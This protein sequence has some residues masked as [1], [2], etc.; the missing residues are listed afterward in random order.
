MGNKWEDELKVSFDDIFSEPDPDDII[1][2]EEETDEQKKEEESAESIQLLH[3][4]MIVLDEFNEKYPKKK[5]IYKEKPTKSYFE[6]YINNCTK[7]QLSI[8]NIKKLSDIF[9]EM[10]DKKCLESNSDSSEELEPELNQVE[11]LEQE[12]IKEAMDEVVNEIDD[13]IFGDQSTAKTTK[14]D[15]EKLTK[16]SEEKKKKI[17]EHGTFVF[18]KYP[19][20]IL[21]WGEDGTSKSEQLLKFM[22]Q[23]GTMI[24]DLENKLLPLATKLNFPLENL[25]IASKYNE[26]YRIDGPNTLQEIRDFI[27]NV[28]IRVQKGDIS[29][30]SI[31][32]DGVTDVRPYAVAEWLYENPDRKQPNTFGDWRSI[33]DKVR[34]ICFTLLNLGIAEN[35]NIFFTSQFR[36]DED[37]IVPNVKEWILH[38]IHHKFKMVRDDVNKKFYAYCEKSYFDP[39]FTIDLTDFQHDLKPSLMNI[40]QDPEL[41]KT[42]QEDFDKGQ[43]DLVQKKVENLF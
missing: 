12:E 22:P 11:E 41:L 29:I 19:I 8:I 5:I 27:E 16:K 31:G 33:N 43:K 17:K 13:S 30:K 23:E 36:K 24:L 20:L 3:F 10:Y 42:Y 38:I 14:K 37:K 39:F 2:S 32:V 28:R 6:F 40:L 4:D 9:R 21:L 18:N 15:T 26:K 35:I 34:D 7:E 1:D 25:I